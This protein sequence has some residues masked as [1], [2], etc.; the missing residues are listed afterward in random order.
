MKLLI[1]QYLAIALCS[2]CL[3]AHCECTST[4]V[5]STASVSRAGMGWARLGP[6][7]GGGGGGGGGSQ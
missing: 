6:I 2:G 7:Y 1:L 3:E 5:H 4:S